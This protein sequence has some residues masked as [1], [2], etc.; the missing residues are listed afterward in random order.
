MQ[1]EGHLERGLQPERG[2]GGVFPEVLALELACLP[3]KVAETAL[4]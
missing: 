3:P 1:I 4:V 2:Q